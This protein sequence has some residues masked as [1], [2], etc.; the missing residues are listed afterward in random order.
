MW[1]WRYEVVDEL[2]RFQER[3]P[4]N[5][6]YAWNYQEFS[7]PY[8]CLATEMKVGPYYINLIVHGLPNIQVSCRCSCRMMI[9]HHHDVRWRHLM[10]HPQVNVRDPQDFIQRLFYRFLIETVTEHKVVCLKTLTW[11]YIHYHQQIGPVNFIENLLYI[12]GTWVVD[13]R[14]SRDWMMYRKPNREIIGNILLFLYE[15]VTLNV[16]NLNTFICK[17]TSL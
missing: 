14:K 6:K 3:G 10:S 13:G 15:A 9:S 16:T 17:S 8:N 7:V 4:K 11:L 1:M 5:R 2:M 12:L